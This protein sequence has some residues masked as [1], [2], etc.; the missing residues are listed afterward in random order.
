MRNAGLDEVQGGIKVSGR[1]INN[2][3]YAHHERSK[4]P[5][6]HIS[7]KKESP[8]GDQCA[9]KGVLLPFLMLLPGRTTSISSDYATFLYFCFQESPT[10][11]F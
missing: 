8:F 11:K 9:S 5:A 1:N 4:R 2:L 3:R 10:P 6:G 7:I